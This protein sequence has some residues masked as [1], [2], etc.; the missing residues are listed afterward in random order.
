MGNEFIRYINSMNNANGDTSNA[1]A[2]SQVT[3]EY[4]QSIQVERKLGKKIVESIN[5]GENNTFIITGH[6]GDGKTSILA[7]VLRDLNALPEGS[8]IRIKDEIQLD[9]GKQLIY[10][11]DM[12][13]LS[14]S[15]QIEYMKEI[16][17]APKQGKIGILI[18]NTGPLITN[19][20]DVICEEGN[21]EKKDEVQNKLLE[22][23]DE[24]YDTPIG[25]EWGYEFYLV[26]LARL[27][28]T[29]FVESLINKIVDE[30]LWVKCGECGQE[31]KCP[32]YFNYKCLKENRDSVVAFINDYYRY[33][34]ELDKRMTIRQIISHISFALTGNLDC[35]KISKKVGSLYYNFTYNFAN[36]F[37]GYIGLFQDSQALQIRSIEEINKLGLHKKSLK[38][39]Y[40]LFVRNDFSRFKPLVREVVE[41][42]ANSAEKKYCVLQD[43]DGKKKENKEGLM[44][45]RQ[46]IRRFMLMYNYINYEFKKDLSSEVFSGVFKMY[47]ESIFTSMK[48]SDLRVFNSIIFNALYIHYMG[49]TPQNKQTLYITLRRKDQLSQNAFL[50]LGEVSHE[51]IQLKQKLVKNKFEDGNEGKYILQLDLPNKAYKIDFPLLN[52]FYELTRGEIYTQINSNLTHGLAKLDTRL[53]QEFRYKNEDNKFNILMNNSSGP[54]VMKFELED[55]KLYVD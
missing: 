8:S 43:D 24:N 33:L 18:S 44:K 28:N 1:L 27:D 10:V 35:S 38:E 53:L 12:S 26:N 25:V 46:S 50:L 52:Y 37:F 34:Y 42:Y 19:F 4:Y 32:V 11:K 15:K 31:E 2:E 36:L 5:N 16:L 7:Q 29:W 23:L 51:K 17:D 14:K 54:Y 40:A 20:V 47:K 13:E 45:Y 49:I 30:K 3:N 22:C 41:K 21:E 9:N 39:D 6:A 48:R 55:K